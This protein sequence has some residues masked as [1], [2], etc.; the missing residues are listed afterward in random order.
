MEDVPGALLGVL[1]CWRLFPETIRGSAQLIRSFGASDSP[2]SVNLASFTHRPCSSPH[3]VE[4]VLPC[5]GVPHSARVASPGVTPPPAS[6]AEL[7]LPP[8]CFQSRQANGHLTA[9]SSALF[10]ECLVNREVQ[11]LCD[12]VAH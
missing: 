7:P 6:S 2:S 8:S 5:R 4:P 11:I 12:W 1:P 3:S 10:S 9:T